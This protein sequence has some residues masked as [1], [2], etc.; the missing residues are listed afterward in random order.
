MID[1]DLYCS[2]FTFTKCTHSKSHLMGTRPLKNT[3]EQIHLLCKDNVQSRLFIF[4]SCK[5]QVIEMISLI[6]VCKNFSEAAT[7][8]VKGVLRNFTKFIG[9]HLCQG[10]FFDKLA[11]LRSATLLK[12]R[13]WLRCF[14]VNF[15]ELLRTPFL[16]NTSG[17]VLLLFEMSLPIKVCIRIVGIN[18]QTVL[19]S[20]DTNAFNVVFGTPYLD[21][22]ETNVI[23]FKILR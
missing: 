23:P 9:K 1:Q 7:G 16:Q 10:L 4:V 21:I 14:H 2:Y 20:S 12:E 22:N 8:G 18:S 13:L 15:A 11:G 6:I 3:L 19:D 5:W 17:R